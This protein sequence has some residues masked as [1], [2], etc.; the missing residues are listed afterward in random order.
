MSKTKLTRRDF[1]MLSGS[2]AAISIVGI[3]CDPVSETEEG[4]RTVFLLSARGR[5]ASQ[6]EKKHYANRLYATED[7]A[8]ADLPHPGANPRV[9]MITISKSRFNELF[10]N[11]RSLVVD[12]RSI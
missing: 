9:V 4:T 11:G 5:R 7:A 10:D 1:I 3:S 12:L 8:L 6:A 2:L